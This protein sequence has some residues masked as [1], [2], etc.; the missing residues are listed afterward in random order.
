MFEMLSKI[1]DELLRYRESPIQSTE[2][3]RRLKHNKHLCPVVEG[4]LNLIIGCF[5]KFHNIAY[6]IQGIHDRGTDVLLRCSENSESQGSNPCFIAFQI[7]SFEDINSEDYLKNL[8]A[9]C[10]EAENEYGG[11]LG[12]YYILLCT[13]KSV[14]ENQIR[15][16][17]KTFGASSNVS[18]IDPVYV[19][20][21]LRLNE[22]RI[23]AFVDSALRK[24]DFVFEKAREMIEELIP[25]EIA[26]ALAIVYEFIINPRLNP[27][28]EAIKNGDFMRE[29]Y[30]KVPDYPRNYY[31]F[32]EE[33]EY[34]KEYFHEGDEEFEREV[35]KLSKE[36]GVKWENGGF[37]PPA[38]RERDT[39]TRIN[40]DLDV[41]DGRLFSIDGDSGEMELDLDYAL[42]IKAVLLDAMVRYGYKNCD[43]LDYIF[44]ALGVMKVFGF[45]INATLDIG[46]EV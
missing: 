44:D 29:V 26:L 34:F 20:T 19:M 27:D 24:D 23:N 31:F 7:K 41:L 32:D 15:E 6:D 2:S 12:H 11:T 42:P 18:V 36:Y 35:N 45:E 10:F 40:Q 13:D 21:F 17:K 39:N 14:H 8:K 1:I 43:L 37:K 33:L 30:R 22:I 28:I 16:I 38:D 25:T 4:R 3:F 5:S 9:Q 46:E